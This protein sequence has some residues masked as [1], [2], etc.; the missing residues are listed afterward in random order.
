MRHFI[1]S[2]WAASCVAALTTAAGSARAAQLT[3]VE[4]MGKIVGFGKLAIFVQTEKGQKFIA[5]VDPQRVDDNVM[6]TGI[7]E[8]KIRVTGKEPASFL[9]PGMFV[10]FEANLAGKGKSRSAADRVSQ[11]TVFTPGKD[12]RP[13]AYGWKAITGGCAVGITLERDG[14][15]ARQVSARIPK[16]GVN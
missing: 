8:P 11:V 6:Y 5:S 13:N 9:R 12:L 16:E 10:R 7:P 14:A 4:V 3:A 15:A 1:R 2:L